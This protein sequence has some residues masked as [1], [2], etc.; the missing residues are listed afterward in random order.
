MKKKNDLERK[1]EAAPTRTPKIVN[2]APIVFLKGTVY[3]G[4]W[5]LFVF[6]VGLCSSIGTPRDLR[7]SPIAAAVS[8]SLAPLSKRVREEW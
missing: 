3:T 8:L 5:L 6:I 2:K 4:L 1:G 7:R